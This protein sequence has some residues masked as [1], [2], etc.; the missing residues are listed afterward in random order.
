MNVD[1]V[2]RTQES[3]SSAILHRKLRTTGP[4]RLPKKYQNV[5]LTSE[6]VAATITTS[7]KFS[8][9]CPA[10]A[11]AASSSGAAGIGQSSL[12]HQYPEKQQEIAVLH[13]ELQGLSHGITNRKAR[14]CS[15]ARERRKI[16]PWIQGGTLTC[17]SRRRS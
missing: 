1:S 14:Y 4:L 13:Y 2:R 5:S 6:P 15:D 10:S 7:A 8:W 11:P 16:P 12:L 9:C 17:S 3:G